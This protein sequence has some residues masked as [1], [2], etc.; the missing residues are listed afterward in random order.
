[1]ARAVPRASSRADRPFIY[2]SCPR[3]DAED[4]VYG[5]G[6]Q[7]SDRTRPG[8][9]SLADG[10][11]LYLEGVESLSRDD[12][13]SLLRALRRVAKAR[14]VG[15]TPSP[16]VRLIVWSSRDLAEEAR[17]GDFHHELVR[18]LAGC[19]LAI[20]AL[21]DRREDIVALATC[22]AAA[23]ARSLGKTLE[24]LS[25]DSRERLM[26]YSWPGNLAELQ[27]VV[28]R[29]VVLSSGSEAVVPPE[30]LREGRR[31]GEYTLV[32]Q[33]GAGAMG[34]VWLAHHSMLVR[35]SALKLIR[36]EALEPSDDEGP[37]PDV[38]IERFRREAQAT[39]RLRSPHTVELYDFGATDE[40]GFYY[41]MEYLDGVDLDFL[42]KKFG[43]I[44][45]ARSICLLRQACMSLAEAH[46]AGLVHR[47]V[48]AANLFVCQLG[49]HFDFVKLL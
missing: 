16:D 19:R 25:A 31:I 35:P 37:S 22:I 18:E 44:S 9:F 32:R 3:A 36:Q 47:D 30:L 5:F 17:E 12:Q 20:P 7:Q 29:S 48:K 6:D 42:V 24:G 2:V 14:A 10:G 1:M 28:E 38:L 8:K 46:D 23:H 11:T 13:E 4:D 45:P 15:Q 34:E 40:G 27:S 49:P 39:A 41:V 21:A 43:P 26:C 33:L